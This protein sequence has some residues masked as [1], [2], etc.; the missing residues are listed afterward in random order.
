MT[1]IMTVV[2]L[3][4]IVRLIIMISDS[5]ALRCR[6]CYDDSLSIVIMTVIASFANAEDATMVDIMRVIIFIIFMMMLAQSQLAS[7]SS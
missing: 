7:S 1:L 2:S 5:A 3:I 4:I 6:G